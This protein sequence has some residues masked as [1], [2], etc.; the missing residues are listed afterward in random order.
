MDLK[1][2]I[3]DTIAYHEEEAKHDNYA[4]SMLAI[5]K[6]N[7]YFPS[8]QVKSFFKNNNL[9]L[10]HNSYKNLSSEN[11]DK[12]YEQCRSIVLDFKADQEDKI[13]VSYA[14]NIPVRISCEEYKE[15]LFSEDDTLSIAYEATMITVYNYNNEW[16]VGTSSCPNAKYSRFVHPTKSHGEMFN[17]AIKSTFNIEGDLK[18]ILTSKLDV[19]IAYEFALVHYQNVK[20]VDYT[21]EFGENYKKIFLVSS[22]QR[23][24]TKSYYTN[25]NGIERVPEFDTVTEALEYVEKDNTFGVIVRKAN[26]EK[27]KVTKNS[28]LFKEQTNPGY[29]NIWKSIL[30]VFCQQRVDYSINDFIKLYGN[31]IEYPI[32]KNGDNIEPNCLILSCFIV[33]RDILYYL[34]INTTEYF[35]HYNRFRMNKELDCTYP[36]IIRFHLAQLR[37][38]QVT[39]YSEKRK[40]IT[41][42]EVEHYLCHKNNIKN[43]MNLIHFFANNGGGYDID[44]KT[45]INLTILDGF[46]L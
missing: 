15:K 14:D 11:N 19:N 7:H 33:I 20:F 9:V 21:E 18:D 45:A 22:I 26:G 32:D 13:V 44:E 4:K 16:Y 3:A 25:I 2:L 42:N 30:W 46:L 17:E 39:D 40:I 23:S 12:L 34:F 24:S 37:H 31:N 28:I 41:N 5:L 36:P 27:Y 6:R 35:S 43:M 10:C 38:L 29:S 1:Q 8:I